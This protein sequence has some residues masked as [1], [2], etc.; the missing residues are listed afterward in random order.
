LGMSSRRAA[1]VL[2]RAFTDPVAVAVAWRIWT[3]DSR[4]DGAKS[5][6]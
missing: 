6:R 5:Q 3:Y 4:T 1:T 2:P